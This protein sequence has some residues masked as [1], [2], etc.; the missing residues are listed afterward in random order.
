MSASVR[1]DRINVRIDPASTI[2]IHVANRTPARAAS[3][4][5]D[6][7]GAAAKTTATSTSEWVTAAS[8]ELAPARTL[9]AVRAIAAVAATPPNTGTTRLASPC[10]NSSR[11][12]SCR[13]PTL[14]PSATVAHNKLSS[15]A[16]AATARAAVT[17]EPAVPRSTNP[18][19][20]AGRL[21]G[22]W[23]SDARFMSSDLEATV[24]MATPASAYGTR[25]RQRAPPSMRAATPTATTT[26]ASRGSLDVLTDGIGR[27]RP[28]PVAVDIG[29]TQC[30]RQL[31]Q[32]DHHG[33][34]GGEP[35]D[36]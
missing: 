36:H 16:R 31:L 7:R 22:R 30:R 33:D 18:N 20:G 13:S 4:M 5:S 8:R 10:P 15:A 25:G 24:A 12:G 28:D 19:E 11:S 35:L 32:G 34:P 26:G 9:T 14:M 29:D 1:V 17:S 2:R 23:P 21:D 3:G 6:T 27:A